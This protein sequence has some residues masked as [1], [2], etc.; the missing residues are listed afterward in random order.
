MSRYRGSIMS[1]KKQHEDTI[2]ISIEMPEK[3]FTLIKEM[4]KISNSQ[5]HTQL[6]AEDLISKLAVQ[7]FGTRNSIDIM[8][9][10]LQK[11]PELLATEKEIIEKIDK[12]FNETV[13]KL[14]MIA[15]EANKCFHTVIDKLETLHT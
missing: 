9:Y 8:S 1:T 11:L 4:A 12:E 6:T 2:H 7:Y 5:L 3:L 15:N 10:S 13:T 14:D